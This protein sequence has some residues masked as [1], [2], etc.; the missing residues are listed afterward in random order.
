MF[1]NL[2]LL[3]STLSC[4]IIFPISPKNLSLF[5][6]GFKTAKS[7]LR[8]KPSQRHFSGRFEKPGQG[9]RQ[10][11]NKSAYPHIAST[12]QSRQIRPPIIAI[13][14]AQPLP[15][16]RLSTSTFSC[17]ISCRTSSQSFE[18]LRKTEISTLHHT[19]E[20]PLARHRASTRQQVCFLPLYAIRWKL[21]LK[22][23]L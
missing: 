19:N 10:H 15:E 7:A 3:H 20:S 17:K 11:H 6:S 12:S 21:P 2:S 8:K 4:Q 14:T 22:F 23:A 5:H 18:S 1:Q 16:P 13:I 9:M